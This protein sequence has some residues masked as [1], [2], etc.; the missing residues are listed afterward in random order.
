MIMKLIFLID[1]HKTM[2]GGDYAQFKFAEYL[3]KSGHDVI[4]FAAN[5]YPFLD[6]LKVKNLD[7]RFRGEVPRT[8]KGIG[9]LNRL[10]GKLY[11][12]FVI[13][14]FIRKNHMNTD[15]IIGYL[16]ESAINAVKL[17]KKYQIK[18]ANFIFENPSWM[19]KQIGDRFIKE[20]KGKFRESWDKAQDA[21]K[22]TYILIP[23]SHL[24]ME[25]CSSWLHRKI[26]EPVYPGV[27]SIALGQKILEHEQIIYLGR[28]NEYKNVNE[29]IEA[30]HLIE[31][32][33]KLVVIGE[34]EEKRRL[35]HLAEKLGIECE[36]KGE[37]N[38]DDKWL[39]IRKSKFMIFPSSFE[40][41]G[42]PPAESLMCGKPCIC[43]DIP[44]FR[45]VYKDKVEYFKEHNL[46]ELTKKIEF[47]LD[48][49]KYR[50]KRGESGRKYILSRYSWEK[51]AAK[52]EKIL[53]N[54]K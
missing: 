47:L 27:D 54:G 18:T 51:S 10:W 50:K 39:E 32:P 15:Y 29:I 36:F 26:S 33:P 19:K 38:D 30:L 3:A 25:E 45:E 35:M 7:M 42:M 9:M 40:G 52:I 5:K 20:Y 2:G 31:Y 14:P 8:I 1:N 22:E 6:N 41:F 48:N 49:P 43:S 34:G 28:L 16:R 37:L 12:F 4:V 23:N 13:E 17:G 24:T 21:Y 53:K 46:N 11:S 44:I